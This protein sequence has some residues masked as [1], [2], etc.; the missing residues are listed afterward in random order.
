MFVTRLI[1]EADSLVRNINELAGRDCAVANH[2]QS[3]VSAEDMRRADT[4]VITHA[5]Y[6]KA[7]ESKI[8]NGRDRWSDYIDWEFGKRRLTIIDESLGEIIDNYQVKAEDVRYALGFINPD[9]RRDNPWAVAAVEEIHSVLNKLADLVDQQAQRPSFAEE[10]SV[11]FE[12]GKDDGHTR[13]VWRSV[14]D[15]KVQ[16]PDNMGIGALRDVMLGLPYDHMSLKR[17]SVFD[18]ERI[19]NRVD[20]TLKGCEAV[21]SRW[22][23]YAKKGKD[24][25]LNASQLLLPPGLPGPVVLDAT[26]RHNFLWELL[27]ERAFI[28]PAPPKVRSYV[29]VTL[30]VAHGLGIGKTKMLQRANE[31][32]PKLLASLGDA[33]APSRRVLLCVHK[34]IEEG[35]GNVGGN[36]AGRC[37][38]PGLDQHHARRRIF[39]KSRGEDRTGATAADDQDVWVI[40]G[41]RASPSGERN[42]ELEAQRNQVGGGKSSPRGV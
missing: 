39:G 26:A 6:V 12:V 7:L 33:I 31:R 10:P 8:G 30:H 16:F 32:V 40:H 13:I 18:R 17:S 3:R 28:Y 9:L 11:A 35:V 1:A 27:G 4:L 2:S 41:R 15:G 34:G 5:A 19:A 29:N 24:H 22:A 23:F 20:A 36:R 42:G 37:V 14:N 21:L 25:T 38:A